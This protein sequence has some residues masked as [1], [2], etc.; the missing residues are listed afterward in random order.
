[1]DGNAVGLKAIGRQGED[2]IDQAKLKLL[3]DKARGLNEPT[4]T[5]NQKLVAVEGAIR[6]LDLGVTASFE[7]EAGVGSVWLTWGKR[8]GEWLLLIETQGRSQ[9]QPLK[10]ASRK[11]RAMAAVHLDKLLDVL[12]KTVEDETM[13]VE[14]ANKKL[15]ELLMAFEE[16]RAQ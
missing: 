9:E 15:D 3:G 7:M 4:D 6:S 14:L 10:S 12:M 16:S 8:G 5:L 11:H 13:R 1:M 2:V